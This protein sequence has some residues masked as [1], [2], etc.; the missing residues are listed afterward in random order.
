MIETMILAMT[1]SVTS[2][3]VAQVKKLYSIKYSDRKKTILR[4]L[5]LVLSFG[6]TFAASLADGTPLS[7]QYLQEVVTGVLLF[8]ASQIPYWYGKLKA[9]SSV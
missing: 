9:K 5:A 6:G 1:P 4:T 8:G 2:W 7:D 3:I